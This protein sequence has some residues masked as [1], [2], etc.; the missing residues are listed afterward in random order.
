MLPPGDWPDASGNPGGACK[1]P[2]IPAYLPPA[3]C[4]MM[5]AGYGRS[6]DGPEHAP[7]EWRYARRT[8]NQIS[9]FLKRP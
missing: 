9:G 5:T 7:S 6:P 3:V 8:R 2:E 4:D 1:L